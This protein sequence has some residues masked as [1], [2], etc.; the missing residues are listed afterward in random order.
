[1]NFAAASADETPTPTPTP[2][3]VINSVTSASGTV[4]TAFSY[5]ITGSNNPTSFDATPLPSG[6]SVNASTG[7]I[8]GTPTTAGNATVTLTA[9]NAG[10]SDTETLTITIV[11]PVQPPVINS[12][13]S[14]SGTVGTAFSYTITGSNE[15][16]S[17]D[18]TPLPSGLSVN[19]STGVISGTP[20]TAGNTTVTLTATNAGGSDTEILTIRIATA[21]TARPGITSGG[22]ASGTRGV[23]F[24]YQITANQTVT[25]YSLTG[26]LIAGLTFD[27]TTGLISGTPTTFGNTTH[28]ITA[29]NSFGSGNRS[30]T[31][32]IANVLP[33]VT[34]SPSASGTQGV[35]FSYQITAT[36]LPIIAYRVAGTLPAGLTLNATSGVIS[37]TPTGTGSF[38]FGLVARNSAGNSTVQPLALQIA[39]APLPDINSVGT[40]DN[41]P[42]E[43]FNTQPT[44][45]LTVNATNAVRYQRRFNGTPIKGA[46]GA[47]HNIGL[48]SATKVGNYTVVA[49]NSSNQSVTSGNITFT[50][51]PVATLTV[52]A[53]DQ[54]I[55]PGFNAVYSLGENASFSTNIT[56]SFGTPSYQWFRNNVAITTNGTSANYSIPSVSA[57]NA[58]GAYK[59]LVTMRNSNTIIGTVQS[60]EWIVSVDGAPSIT[61]PESLSA[62]VGTPFTFNA[63]VVGNATALTLNGTLPT[64]LS[65]NGTQRRISGTPSKTGTFPLR[66]TPSSLSTG[67]GATA[68]FSIVVSNPPTP[69]NPTVN[70]NGNATASSVDSYNTFPGP[71]LQVVPNNPDSHPLRYQWRLNGKAIPGATNA[72]YS[73]G[74]AS[75]A[76]TGIYDVVLTNAVGISTASRQVSFSLTPAAGF[77]ISGPV[78]QQ[79]ALGSNA[80]FSVGNLS[81]PTNA[82]ATYRWFRNGVVINGATGSSYN[83]PVNAGTAGSYSVEVTSKIGATTIGSVL[84]KSWSVALQDN[85]AGVLIYNITGNATRSIGSTETTGSYT[86][87][88]VVDR[89]NNNAAFIQ[90]YTNGFAKRNSLED[91]PDIA[92]AS[93]GPVVGSRTVFAGSMYAGDE[94]NIDHDLVWITG[95]DVENTV[96][97]ATSTPSVLPA[98][99]VFAPATMSGI[100]GML[101]RDGA[102]GPEIDSFN[103]TLTLNNTLTANAYRTN[104]TFEQAIISTRAAAAAAGFINE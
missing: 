25:G 20:T 19:T 39:A 95:R 76:K 83:V 64:G 27:S 82:T 31:I 93:T 72:T 87:Y 62:F 56:D 97:P 70:V 21:A 35:P 69:S 74:A 86:G 36:N 43:A 16:T 98:I 100:A 33:A 55:T 47:T 104:Q 6:L 99:K 96:A 44:P 94:P 66:L 37:G 28:T 22:T 3:P 12:S 24:A 40:F 15:P 13:T 92:A 80:T 49:T 52:F 60:P 17:F 63:T 9:T 1:V 65:Y 103:V 81:L 102:S 14:A 5:T 91:R 10:G 67:A 32:S 2:T 7:V 78:N 88:M 71:I 11:E 4:G 89:I 8:S 46:I 45:S 34:S 84:S 61:T 53:G 51:K 26:N 73:V 18:A 85:S 38:S 75:A 41:V 58:P 59:V 54:S 50:L 79:L 68:V 101:I 30:L 42:F 23:A 57:T 90:T 77:G 29:T 48:A